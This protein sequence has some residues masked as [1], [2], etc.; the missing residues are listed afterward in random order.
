MA[1]LQK[2]VFRPGGMVSDYAETA[3]PQG[4]YREVI[5][6]RQS[7]DG[8]WESLPGFK[9][10]ATEFE[11]R[12]YYAGK[13]ISDDKS[14][15]RFILAQY[16]ASDVTTMYLGKQDYH[17][18][19]GYAGWPT[20]MSL[21]SGVTIPSTAR[22]RFHVHNGVIRITGPTFPLRYEYIKRHFFPELSGES[23]DQEFEDWFLDKACVN[24]VQ[25]I[26]DMPHDIAYGWISSDTYDNTYY[27]L[28]FFWIFDGGQY[29]LPVGEPQFFNGYIGEARIRIRIPATFAGRRETALGVMVATST[30][31]IVN[32]KEAVWKVVD[33]IPLTDEDED[34]ETEIEDID[35]TRR[36]FTHTDWTDRLMPSHDPS[37]GYRPVVQDGYIEPGLKMSIIVDS[38]TSAEDLV[39]E[40][41]DYDSTGYINYI[42]FTTDIPAAVRT[43]LNSNPTDCTLIVERRWVYSDYS[44]DDCYQ[45]ISSFYLDSG[46][47]FWELSDIPANSE[48]VSPAYT[49]F[50]L[51]DGRGY[52]LP[53][54]TDEGDTVRYSPLFQPDVFPALNVFATEVGDGDR[55]V[56]LDVRGGRLV[57]YKEHSISQGKL[58]QNGFSLDIG[59]AKRGLYAGLGRIVIDDVLYFM[60]IDDLY[61]FTGGVPKGLLREVGLQTL[62]QSKVS[63][64]SFLGYNKSRNELWLFLNSTTTL[65]IDL[66]RG[67]N[68]QVQTTVTPTSAFTLNSGE[69]YIGIA[70]TFG[71]FDHSGTADESQVA[72]FYSG[73]HDFGEPEKLKKHH[74]SVVV[75]ESSGAIT[76]YFY[77]VDDYNSSVSAEMP[78]GAT[79][80]NKLK[81]SVTVRPYGF[82]AIAGKMTFDL[83]TTK[84]VKVRGFS[85]EVNDAG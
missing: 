23:H 73:G 70:E 75:W 40:S 48:D 54:A 34:G 20:G 64:D 8:E 55:N 15:D 60:D 36:V 9:K 27:A 12:T 66:N 17:P 19:L 57:I 39:V 31:R 5:N 59:F 3:I 25:D 63:G 47:D 52:A 28:R 41:V 21:P 69:L 76:G 26:D 2:L 67:S 68:F 58:Y 51:L 32:L 13:E 46:P 18:T 79:E 43:A 50:A 14:G 80:T 16:Y 35:Y 24:V 37:S 61:L 4:K 22:C 38:S 56:G 45:I 81:A 65:V 42:K 49:D 74:R 33:I 53:A 71:T 78:I 44:G 11:T 77:L 84:T 6:L 62:Y 1:Q 83:S 72:S 7:R 82:Q 30:K 10:I 29:S 85:I